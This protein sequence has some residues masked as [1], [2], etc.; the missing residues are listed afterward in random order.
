MYQKVIDFAQSKSKIVSLPKSPATITLAI[1]DKLNISP[2]GVYQYSM[3]GKSLYMDTKKIKTKLGWKPKKTNTDTFIEN[4]KW[5]TEHKGSFVEL[6]SGSYSSNR[7][8]PKMGVFK[9]L[10]MLS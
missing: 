6:G 2:L 7:S 4:Y 5:Y 9:L 8:V 10:K 3:I 1:L